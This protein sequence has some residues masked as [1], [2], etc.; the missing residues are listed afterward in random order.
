MN[1]QDALRPADA[2][3]KAQARRMIRMA[4]HGALAT[5]GPDGWPAASRVALAT[6]VDGSPV[7]L[8]STLS[9]HTGAMQDDPRVAL[10]VGE[11]GRGDPLAHPRLTLF[12][13]AAPLSRGE[14]G[15]ARR[16]YLARHPKARLYA[17]FADFGFFRL[18]PDRADFNAGFGAAHALTAADLAPPAD[19]RA[20]AEG[21][22]GAVAHMNA[23]H[24][25]AV[26]HFA[27]LCGADPAGDWA[28]TG[29]DPEGADLACGDDIRRLTF[30]SPVAT[31]GALRAALVAL[32]RRQ[33]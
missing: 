3:A 12:C 1:R 17:D 27:R 23:D 20:L 28:L 6:L 15:D 30:S 32:A 31:P 26:R 16:R 33:V 11:P 22:A 13:R 14:D 8:V 19:W 18:S 4:R 25:D 2:E 5:I 29:I 10:M 9:A 24:A 7:C 21:E